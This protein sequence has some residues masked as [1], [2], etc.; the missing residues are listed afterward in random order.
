MEHWSV[1]FLFFL[2][3]NFVCYT[4]SI[5]AGVGNYFAVVDL[6]LYSDLS[7]ESVGFDDLVLR[8]CL[9]DEDALGFH[10]IVQVNRRKGGMC[11]GMVGRRR[12]TTKCRHT[13]DTYVYTLISL[14]FLV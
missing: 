3:H 7:Q 1:P 8:A 9:V 4:Q 5:T 13:C 2:L 12:A 10:T 6:S 11:R 14:L